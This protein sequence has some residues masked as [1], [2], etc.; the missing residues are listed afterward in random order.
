MKKILFLALLLPLLLELSAETAAESKAEII[1]FGR[2]IRPILSEYCIQCHGPDEEHR[3]ADLRV[4]DKAHVFE[5]RDGITLVVPGDVEASE[6][7][8]RI[9]STDDDEIMPPPKAKKTMTA[10]EKALLKTWIEEGAKWDEHWSFVAPEKVELSK[11]MHPID[12]LVE[13]GLKE[14]GLD[15]SPPADARTLARRMYLDLNGLPPSP[16]QL[17]TFETAHKADSNKAVNDLKDQLMAQPQYGERMALTWLD[18]ARYGDTSVMH[19]D[20]P[21]DMWPWRDWVVNAYNSNMSYDQFS[22]EQIAGD[23]LPEPTVDQLIASGFNRN[24]A[25]S[26]EGGAIPEELRVEYVVD[27]VR[28]TANVWMGLTMEC[29]QCHD[30]KYDPISHREYFQFF[31]FFNNHKDPGMQS[32]RGNQSPVVNVVA[33]V[34]N[35][36]L[37]EIRAK[38]TKHEKAY[39]E[40]RKKVQPDHVVYRDTVTNLVANLS[41][42]LAPEDIGFMFNSAGIAGRSGVE[43]ARGTRGYIEGKLKVVDDKDLGKAI[44]LAGGSVIF[45]G[46][47]DIDLNGQDITITAWVKPGENTGGAILSDMNVPEAYRGFDLW[48][49]GNKIGMH[50]INTWPGNAVKAVTKEPLKANVWQHVA[51]TWSGKASENKAS[52]LKVRVDG[53][54]METGVQADRLKGTTRSEGSP[55]RLG[56]RSK[57]GFPSCDVE[58]IRIYRRVLTDAELDLTKRNSLAVARAL[59]HAKRNGNQRRLVEESFYI[60]QIPVEKQQSAIAKAKVEEKKITSGKVTSMIM[61]DLPAD[62]MRMTYILD[63]GAYDSPK[64]DDVILP[65]LPA[66]LPPIALLGDDTEAVSGSNRLDLARWL[67]Q[68]D[69]PL[70]SRVTVNMIWQQFFGYGLVTTPGDFGS[71]GAYPTHPELLDWLA[72]DLRENGWDIKRLVSQIVTSKTYQQQSRVTHD[73]DPSNT[74]L[75]RAPR[76]RLQSELVRDM[77]LSTSGLLKLDVGGPGV[78]PPQPPGLWAEVSL[79]GNP[80]FVKDTGD[81]QYRRSIYTYWKRSAPAPTMQLFDAPTREVCV[82]KR[83]R[84]NTPLQ[85]L[86]TMNDDQFVEAARHLAERLLKDGTRSITDQHRYGYELVSGQ[87]PSDEVL[88]VMQ[89]VYDIALEKYTAD[90]QAA[91]A[92]LS[93]GDSKRDEALPLAEHAATTI[94]GNLLLNLDVTFT[95]E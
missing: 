50:I 75:S 47:P 55:F 9:T 54:W 95:R 89:Q 18:A 8:A 31:A 93:V 76:Y 6:L 65:G 35:D 87:L 59:P 2:D 14:Q 28:T 26:D 3:G 62:K 5:D 45:D 70:T 38:I 1:D 88:A 25:T 90:E 19:A 78:K 24:N 52:G 77:A 56:G 43:L 72:V 85:A 61:E 53:K 11:E 39:N 7:W 71:Q 63:R 13:V 69:H 51:V 20:G 40:V 23:L 16:E 37:K 29:A 32:R 57:A 94:I 58:E 33:Q 46:F 73:K 60:N 86:V 74:Y 79:G 15:F 68:D 49:E 48:L 17:A 10:K 21:R 4:D 81:R 12:A 92:L 22:I 82:M 36:K 27:R 67:F 66:A 30:H 84:T 91:K 44:R 34:D 64:K 41:T 80:K 83:P 42:N